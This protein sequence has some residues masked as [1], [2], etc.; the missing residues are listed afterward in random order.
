MP[1]FTLN[2]YRSH[3]FHHLVYAFSPFRA[4]IRI[5]RIRIPN[6]LVIAIGCHFEFAE[7]SFAQAL[8]EA[9]GYPA[10]EHSV[11]QVGRLPGTPEIGADDNRTGIKITI[12]LQALLDLGL[13]LR[14]QTEP[15]ATIF[16]IADNNTLLVRNAMTVTHYKIAIVE[17]GDS[18]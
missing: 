2:D 9:E 11:H 7:M 18:Q 8:F 12:L 17:I 5:H 1:L 3:S 4:A 16:R 14:T 15:R 10:V 13:S 6:N